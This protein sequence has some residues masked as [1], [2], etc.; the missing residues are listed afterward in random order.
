MN[1]N[2]PKAKEK[3]I[4]VAFF[5]PYTQSVFFQFLRS[6]CSIPP[7][8]PILWSVWEAGSYLPRSSA[9]QATRTDV[10]YL[11]WRF[12]PFF[13]PHC[14]ASANFLPEGREKCSSP[15]LSSLNWNQE[16]STLTLTSEISRGFSKLM[17][18]YC[19]ATGAANLNFPTQRGGRGWKKLPSKSLCY[20]LGGGQGSCCEVNC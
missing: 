11:T 15:H 10:A 8:R 16:E 19:K 5:P 6:C 9:A 3:K 14:P 17:C 20:I 13:F 18:C 12:L 1:R 7:C 2:R 4:R